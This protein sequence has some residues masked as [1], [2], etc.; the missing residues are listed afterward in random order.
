LQLQLNQISQSAINQNVQLVQ[1]HHI[2]TTAASPEQIN[3]QKY[4]RIIDGDYEFVSLY[5]NSRMLPSPFTNYCKCVFIFSQLKFLTY[6]ELEQRLA[7][8]DKEM[9]KEFDETRKRY[10]AKRKPIVDA[11]EAKQQ[12]RQQ[13]IEEF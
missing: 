11:I 1:H 4:Q 13:K 6:E 10:I 9:E 3:V 12:K 8:L 5:I 7:N 2:V